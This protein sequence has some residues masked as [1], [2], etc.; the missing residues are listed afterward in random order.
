[1][2]ERIASLAQPSPQ[3][4]SYEAMR[5]ATSQERGRCETTRRLSSGRRALRPAL[6]MNVPALAPWAREPPGACGGR[7]SAS[8]DA[9][10][11]PLAAN[12]AGRYTS[13]GS[14]GL[15]PVDSH[16]YTGDR[17]ARPNCTPVLNA[18]GSASGRASSRAAEPA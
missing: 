4:R 5:L 16:R 12:L 9:G 18:H 17:E 3:G 7:S 14:A 10:P 13:P 8:E 6:E 15:D 1:M 2:R 11:P